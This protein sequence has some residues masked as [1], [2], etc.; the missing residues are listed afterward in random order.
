MAVAVE[1][2]DFG[3]PDY[4]C[5]I[6]RHSMFAAMR[7]CE[8]CGIRSLFPHPADQYELITSKSWMATLS[9]HPGGM[10][11]GWVGHGWAMLGCWAPLWVEENP[12]VALADRQSQ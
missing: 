1:A 7:A 6:E 11:E 9:L 10:V 3:D 12:Q 4:A 8:G 5:Y 2:Q